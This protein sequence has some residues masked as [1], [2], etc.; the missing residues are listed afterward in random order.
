[1]KFKE[2]V[3]PFGIKPE[4]AIALQIASLVWLQN[5]QSLVVTSLNDSKHSHTSLHF[6]GC[7]ADLRTWGFP[8]AAV[9]VDQLREAL[10]NN[11]D[12]DVVLEKDHIHLE[13]QPKLRS[14]GV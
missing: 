10:G 1:M 9:V 11:P 5:N 2:G 13:Y 7:A 14:A 12:Y 4:L 8:D 6:A 3:N